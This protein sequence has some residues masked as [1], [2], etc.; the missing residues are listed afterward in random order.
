MIRFGL[1]SLIPALLR[2]PRQ[3]EPVSHPVIRREV[4][5]LQ[6]IVEGQNHEIRR[7]LWRYSSL[8]ERQRSTIQEWRTAVL[9]GE[10][11]LSLWAERLPERYGELCDRLREETLQRAERAVTLHWIDRCWADHLGTVADVREGIHLADVGGLDPLQEFH[12]QI[13][14]TF[15]GLHQTIEDNIVETLATVEVTGKGIDLDKAGVRGPSSTWT[16]LVNDR[17]LSDLQRMLSGPGSS[18][19]GAIGILMT[20]PLL[21]AY[22]LWQRLTGRRE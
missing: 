1:D 3:E 22:W 21:L 12:K 20:W 10:A 6:R 16:Y 9:T 17:V 19:S 18:A 5:R 8:L 7:T 14:E 11:R 2:P 13:A 15:R 4:D